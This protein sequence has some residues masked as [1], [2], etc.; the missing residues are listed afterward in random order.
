MVEDGSSS[1]SADLTASTFIPRVLAMAVE[2]LLQDV[3]HIPQRRTVWSLRVLHPLTSET[4]HCWDHDEVA[5]C[6]RLF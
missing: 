1:R 5:R 2:W 3:S 6:S 4:A